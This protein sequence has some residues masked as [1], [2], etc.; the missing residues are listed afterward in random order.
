MLKLFHENNR[1][2]RNCRWRFKT[3]HLEPTVS[4]IL[5][6]FVNSIYKKGKKKKADGAFIDLSTNKLTPKLGTKNPRLACLRP[7][8]RLSSS[9]QY[10]GGSP[11][12]SLACTGRYLW[13][14]QQQR[15]LHQSSQQI[16]SKEQSPGRSPLWS[17]STERA[18][19]V[20][21][22]QAASSRPNMA[23]WCTENPLVRLL[24]YAVVTGHHN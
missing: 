10:G 1:N 3:G 16:S 6:S 14:S 18:G 8:L 4:I 21:S 13:V 9:F 17:P 24:V 20:R 7:G 2:L 19:P 23:A 15:T 11:S 12:T 5:L 22:R